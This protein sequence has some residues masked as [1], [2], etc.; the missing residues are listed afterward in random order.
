MASAHW[1]AGQP[2]SQADR[3]GDSSPRSDYVVPLG[4]TVPDALNIVLHGR[5]VY[6]VC[7][8][9]RLEQPPVIVSKALISGDSYN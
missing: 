9:L 8:A 5:G 4:T 1:S 2:A 3:W 7:P 6:R